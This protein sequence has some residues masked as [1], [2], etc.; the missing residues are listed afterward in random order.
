MTFFSIPLL[1]KYGIAIKYHGQIGGKILNQGMFSFSTILQAISHK[2]RLILL[3][4]RLTEN[5][6]HGRLLWNGFYANVE[7]FCVH[8]DIHILARINVV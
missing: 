3:K 5:M 8:S 6:L 4:Y 1:E 2:V 7:F